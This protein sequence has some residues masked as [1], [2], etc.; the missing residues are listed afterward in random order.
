MHSWWW[1]GWKLVPPQIRTE[2]PQKLKSRAAM[3]L[4]QS[5][6]ERTLSQHATEVCGFKPKLH[7]S[8]QLGSEARG[9][10]YMHPGILSAPVRVYYQLLTSPKLQKPFS[11]E[12]DPTSFSGPAH[13]ADIT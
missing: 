11:C 9:M 8:P 6:I 4:S 10:C 12:N 5:H 13:L 7:N 3:W 1:E 2:L